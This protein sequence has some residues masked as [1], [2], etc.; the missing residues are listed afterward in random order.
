MEKLVQNKYT[1]KY[2]KM[3]KLIRWKLCKGENLVML[4]NGIH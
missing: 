2:G 4:T 1:S 3:E